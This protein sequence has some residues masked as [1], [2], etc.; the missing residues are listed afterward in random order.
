M[1]TEERTLPIAIIAL[2]AVAVMVVA[3]VALLLAGN[4]AHGEGVDSPDA[5][6]NADHTGTSTPFTAPSGEIV[7][8]VL[9]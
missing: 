7:T 5:C 4:S 6:T 9:H 2:V 1:N 3:A 8:G